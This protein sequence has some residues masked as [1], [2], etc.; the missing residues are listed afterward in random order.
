MKRIFACAILAVA[1][2]VN[3]GTSVEVIGSVAQ[4][5]ASCFAK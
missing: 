5:D 3:A 4:S 1:L 2:V